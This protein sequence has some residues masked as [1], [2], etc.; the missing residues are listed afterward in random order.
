MDISRYKIQSHSDLK[1]AEIKTN[2]SGSYG[3]REDAEKRLVD[4]IQKMAE[5]QS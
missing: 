5:Y 2:D 3:S 1:L 4:N